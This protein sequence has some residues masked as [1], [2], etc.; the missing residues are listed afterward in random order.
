[1]LVAAG[2]AP[3]LWLG[4]SGS[5]RPGPPAGHHAAR[6]ERDSLEDLS[7]EESVEWK[8]REIPL[9]ARARCVPVVSFWPPSILLRERQYGLLFGCPARMEKFPET[10][11][12]ST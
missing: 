12:F 10:E 2:S 3:C 5:R 8:V 9:L 6:N 11:R 4:K 1:M 7:G